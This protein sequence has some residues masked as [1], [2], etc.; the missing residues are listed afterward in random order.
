MEREQIL[1]FTLRIESRH[2]PAQ[3]LL[4]SIKGTAECLNPFTQRMAEAVLGRASICRMG[5]LDEYRVRHDP[6][7]YPYGWV[8]LATEQSLRSDS[9]VMLADAVDD[10]GLRRAKLA[11]RLGEIDYRTIRVASLALGMHAAEQN[12]GRVQLRSWVLEDPMVLEKIRATACTAPF[13]ICARP[14]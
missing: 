13:T 6:A 1:S 7:Q 5:G 11:W 14:A 8:N 3:S 4:K 12:L 9:R 10:F 2:P